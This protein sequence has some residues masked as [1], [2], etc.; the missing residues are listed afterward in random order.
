MVSRKSQNAECIKNDHDPIL[1]LVLCTVAFGS[2]ACNSP[3]SGLY[4][5]ICIVGGIFILYYDVIIGDLL[6][7]GSGVIQIVH[8]EAGLIMGVDPSKREVLDC[9]PELA[10]NQFLMLI[11]QAFEFCYTPYV[12]IFICYEY[13]WSN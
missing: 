12:L 9:G 10:S 5:V 4:I 6:W 13:T 3:L 2:A 7:R 1:Q 8:R 11:S